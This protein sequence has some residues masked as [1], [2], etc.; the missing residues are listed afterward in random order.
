MIAVDLDP[1]FIDSADSY[2][3]DPYLYLENI[4]G[5]ERFEVYQRKVIDTV[6]AND[7]T[8][9]KAC[10][11]LGKTFLAARLV[12][13]ILNV[14]P[15]SK[16][17]TTAPTYNQVERILWAELRAAHAKSKVPLGGKLNMTDW[18]FSPD[19]FAIGF[20]PRNEATGGE[21]QGTSSS[22]QGFHPSDDGYLFIVFDEAT[23]IPHNLWTMAEGLMTSARVK[24]LAIGNPTSTASGFY[25]C[26]KSREWAKVSLSCFDSPNLIANGITDIKKLTKE[27]EKYKALPDAK[28]REFL[29]NYKVV[30]PYLL[31]AKWVVSQAAKWGIEHPLTVS[32]ILGEFPKG[33]DKNLVSL[34]QIE[35]AQVRVYYPVETDRKI[36]GVDVA[37]YGS[38]ATIL[39][40]L[41]GLKQTGKRDFYK[42]GTVEVVGEVV[43]MA[44]EMNNVDVIVV[45]ETG[46]GGGVVDL[47]RDEVGKSLNK[48]CEIRGV[49]FGAG[50]ECDGPDGCQHIACEKAKY[51][52]L[53]ARIFG[54]LRD[55]IKLEEGL[56]LLN[57]AIY[58]E[59]LP[60]IVF[61]YNKK[62]QMVIESKDEYKK[63]TGRPSPDS[64]DSLALA[65]FGRYDEL[66]IG[67]FTKEMKT[68]KTRTAAPSL[69]S[70]RNW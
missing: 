70:Q 7:R 53:K 50:V 31:T 69:K 41:H 52:N 22:F 44:R 38:D 48:N 67:K 26:F 11:D 5:V 64:S 39:T 58:S 36:I 12:M 42:H 47:L 65:N 40:G 9:V 29:N 20:S 23:G 15:G 17:I 4:L 54:L 60:T 25:Q 3:A 8:A 14:F 21:G 33:G 19:W 27:I 55:D 35:E 57:E 59:E 32:K 24:F 62:G 18:T 13:T 61:T 45:D 10:H 16:V 1:A 56:V 63:R 43:A 66:K 51:Y 2:D 46:M 30:R 68:E 6:W 37:R 34:G 28:A 49:Q